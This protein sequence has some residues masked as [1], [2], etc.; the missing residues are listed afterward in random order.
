MCLRCKV[1]VADMKEARIPVATVSPKYELSAQNQKDQASL[2]IIQNEADP[3]E[4]DYE[5]NPAV[6]LE[7]N[8]VSYGK[9]DIQESSMVGSQDA[10][11]QNLLDPSIPSH[12][13][14]DEP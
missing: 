12:T 6:K 5:L 2:G 7:G 9:Q 4:Q 11:Q 14:M 8:G 13:S 1:R 10:L 3:E